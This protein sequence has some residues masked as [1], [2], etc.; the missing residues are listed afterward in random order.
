[1]FRARVSGLGHQVPVQDLR[2]VGSFFA[3]SRGPNQGYL[4][5]VPISLTPSPKPPPPFEYLE[6]EAECGFGFL[7][8]G[9]GSKSSST[10]CAVSSSLK[11]V[12]PMYDGALPS[13]PAIGGGGGV[14]GGV[15]GSK[16]SLQLQPLAVSVWIV[17]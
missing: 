2:F 8:L 13:R 9:S 6:A 7:G 15:R 1:M 16:A 12:R 3:T 14:K 11:G 10:S 17:A 5:K 4:G